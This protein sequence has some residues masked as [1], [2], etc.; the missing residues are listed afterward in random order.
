[1]VAL[2][3]WCTHWLMDRRYG[4]ILAN[5]LE[6]RERIRNFFI[7]SYFLSFNQFML[8]PRTSWVWEFLLC[9]KLS[10]SVQM[11]KC[12]RWYVAH[13]KICMSRS[14][15]FHI[16]TF[17]KLGSGFWSFFVVPG[18]KAPSWNIT[19]GVLGSNFSIHLL[20]CITSEVLCPNPEP[21]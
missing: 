9:G 17:S 19:E 10:K 1:M 5:I 11:H 16:W 15:F 20:L 14:P 12:S 7:L 21:W 3:F 4:L 2:T 13:V 18:D 8:F 6:W